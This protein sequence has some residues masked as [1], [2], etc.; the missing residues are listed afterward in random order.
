MC[1][2][3]RHAYVINIECTNH[4]IVQDNIFLG[5]YGI[6][7]NCIMKLL[8]C[9]LR[10]R[11]DIFGFP[12]HFVSS[13][14]N[15]SHLPDVLTE[16]TAQPLRGKASLLSPFPSIFTLHIY[17]GKKIERSTYLRVFFFYTLLCI[18]YKPSGGLFEAM[19]KL[20]CI[21][22]QWLRF[23]PLCMHCKGTQGLLYTQYFFFRFFKRNFE[24][25][26]EKKLNFC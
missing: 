24:K 21:L 12:Q 17:M 11:R 19:K 7:L 25:L 16:S 2:L 26:R 23:F 3:S 1:T 13:L 9:G 20:I 4:P 10:W 22:K 5:F 6:I 14:S 8:F 15:T 18:H